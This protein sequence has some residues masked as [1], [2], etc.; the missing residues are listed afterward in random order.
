MAGLIST[1]QMAVCSEMP[2]LTALT[3]TLRNMLLRG[4]ED[5]RLTEMR[6][7]GVA[8]PRSFTSSAAAFGGPDN[9]GRVD[10]VVVN[11]DAPAAILRNTMDEPGHWIRFRVLDAN[12]RDALG[13]LLTAVLVI[14]DYLGP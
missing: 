14:D 9:D 5:G 13:A 1:K 4:G 2:L 3:P 6:P 11:R 7:R 8:S 12:G 10:I